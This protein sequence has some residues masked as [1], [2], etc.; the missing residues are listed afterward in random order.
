MSPAQMQQLQ[1]IL[2]QIQMAM[3][4]RPQVNMQPLQNY[5]QGLPG[6][7]GL[8]AQFKSLY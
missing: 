1:N 2:P 4:Q 3:A 8:P 5:L 6:P 7:L